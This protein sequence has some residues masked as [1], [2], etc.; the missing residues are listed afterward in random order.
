MADKIF[1]TIYT[2]TNVFVDPLGTASTF[3][4]GANATW[5]HGNAD[6][7][8]LN[9]AQN[10]TFS[11]NVPRADVNV[12]GVTGT[13]DRPQLEAET[14]TFE[15]GYIPENI[16]SP[17]SSQAYTLNAGD[18]NALIS[19]AIAEA[20]DYVEAGAPKVG[21]VT[22]ALMNSATGEA[23]VGALPTFTISLTGSQKVKAD[24]AMRLNSTASGG[25]V[26]DAPKYV[27]N[28]TEAAVPTKAK[29]LVNKAAIVTP[30]DVK[31]TVL[32]GGNHVGAMSSGSFT[33]NDPQ[34][35]VDEGFPDQDGD[36]LIESCAQS[37][38]WAWDV[39][40]ET[41]LCLGSDPAEDGLALGN[42]P[43][44]SSFT[45][46]ALKEQL[47]SVPTSN[48]RLTIGIYN[49]LLASGNIDSRTH[50]LAI[51][52]LYGS[53]NYVIGGTGDGFTVD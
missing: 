27:N 3:D 28:T 26:G 49:F 32:V 41:I 24:P 39:P 1:R 9:T 31:L 42:P 18:I 52:D 48:F 29:D 6:H 20:P 51:G 15:F 30:Q 2:G 12:F 43:G 25:V 23:T 33:S 8:W 34:A 44:T 40:V 53:Y 7:T 50:S 45:V 46:E 36:D 35:L 38:S 21:M 16:A 4:G 11:I 19:D 17:A 5:T 10:A 47:V 13:L 22:N 14:A 37:A